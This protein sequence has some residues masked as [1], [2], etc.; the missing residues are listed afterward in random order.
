MKRNYKSISEI[1]MVITGKTPSTNNDSFFEGPFPFITPSDIHTYDEKYLMSTER[2]LSESGANIL[3]SNKLPPN[4]ICFVCIGSTI[5]K[6][7]KTNQVSYT[8]QQ[9]NS[10]VPKSSYDSDYIFYYLRY[11]K[12][13]FQ[14]VGGGTGSGKGIVN[15]SLFS[16]T[17]IEVIEDKKKQF[18]VA[19]ILSTFDALIE[20]N[21]KR[22]K[23]LEQMAENL[24]KEWF[25]RFRFP[26][27]ENTRFENGFPSCWEEKRLCDFGI[28]LDSGSRPSGGIDDSIV[29]G[30]ASLGAEAVNGL[31]EFDYSNVKMISKEYYT[32]MNRGKSTGNDI[33]V[34]KDGAYIGK[35][36]MFRNDFPFKEFAVNEHVFLLSAT[37]NEYQ[38]YLYFTLHLPEY[39]ILMQNLNRNA[40]QPGL[41]KLDIY[42]IKITIPD[43]KT[44]LLFNSF[45]EPIIDE[46]FNIAKQNRI[47]AKQRDLLLPRLMSGRL[48]V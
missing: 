29:D 46:I 38:N 31:A 12:S 7:C 11:V 13:Y 17:K 39:F 32:K 15:K 28:T 35:I 41:S 45:V 2:T 36:T 9:I 3:K 43:K 23:I 47:L 19:S 34:Y 10:I 33:L 4:S 21:N 5:G 18:E 40:A 44:I 37:D 25:V 30:I 1:G 20:V 48:E 6:M 14:L 27:N 22:I 42:K 24:Y 26:G 8:N 16:K